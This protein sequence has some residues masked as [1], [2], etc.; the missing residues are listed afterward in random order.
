LIHIRLI[1]KNCQNATL[2]LHEVT[3]YYR[4]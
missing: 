3:Q 1:V 4:M 2:H